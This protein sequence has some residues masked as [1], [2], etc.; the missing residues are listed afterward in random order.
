[1]SGAQRSLFWA[2]HC[3]PSSGCRHSGAR[4]GRALPPAG[5][6]PSAWPLSAFAHV[7]SGGHPRSTQLQ[8]GPQ[9]NR[10]LRRAPCGDSVFSSPCRAS[11]GRDSAQGP[12]PVNGDGELLRRPSLL[13]FLTSERVKVVA[14]IA[15]A[16]A[17][18]NA[19]RV[20][21]SVAIVPMSAARGWTKSFAGVV[22]VI[23][24]LRFQFLAGIRTKNSHSLAKRGLV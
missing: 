2:A 7:S 14:M 3:P 21:M 22:Q 12:S 24:S 6:R 18:C 15:M 19:D 23:I 17:L 4:W 5:C 10:L 13:E 9:G 16:L 1:M 8:G 11:Q 20:V